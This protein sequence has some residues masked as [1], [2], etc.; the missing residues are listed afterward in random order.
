M[1]EQGILSRGVGELAVSEIVY[2]YHTDP[3]LFVLARYLNAQ[4]DETIN[5]TPLV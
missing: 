3:H 4:P 5:M 2:D 1:T